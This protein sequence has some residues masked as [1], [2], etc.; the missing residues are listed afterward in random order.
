MDERIVKQYIIS[1]TH[2]YH[3]G[4]IKYC[5]RPENFNDIIIRRWKSVVGE[6][7]IIF[8]LGDVIW[9]NRDSLVG[10][11]AQLPGTKILVRGNHDKS[12]SN[13]WF[14][15]SGFSLVVEKVQVS[16]VIL[17]HVPVP[18]TEE[19]IKRGT[20]NIHGHFHNNR[21]EKWE[22]GYTERITESHY[23]FSLEELDYFPVNL[24]KARKGKVLIPSIKRIRNEV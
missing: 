12:R 20:I 8:H 23:L 19:E 21:S 13:N 3:D 22:R 15:N 1:D 9:G 16:G 24:D 14:L 7:D 18:L 10:I 17:S 4:M 6:D 5:G 11:M 2:F